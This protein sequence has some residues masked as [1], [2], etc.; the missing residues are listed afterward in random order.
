MKT[1]KIEALPA[2]FVVGV[3]EGSGQDLAHVGHVEQ[4]QRN[5]QQSVENRGQFTQ[6][7]LRS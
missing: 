1:L 6:R 2:H 5:A 4:H 3:F 7:R